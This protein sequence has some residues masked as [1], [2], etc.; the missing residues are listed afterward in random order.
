M[1]ETNVPSEC[2]HSPKDHD[3]NLHCYKNLMSL[4]LCYV[5]YLLDLFVEATNI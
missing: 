4:L 3:M 1:S 5:S 2:V